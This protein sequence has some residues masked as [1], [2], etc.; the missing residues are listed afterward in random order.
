MTFVAPLP[1]TAAELS[2]RDIL[3]LV[4]RG[5][6]AIML[7]AFLGLAAT[8]LFLMMA[9]PQYRIT[10]LVAPA[11]RAGKAD[12][13]ALLPD[14]PSFALQYL[15]NSVGTQD[16]SDFIRFESALRAPSVAATI[17]RDPVIRDGL[18][19]GGR[20]IFSRAPDLESPAAV[21]ADL[22][23]GI[24]IDPVG[25]TPL[26][27][28]TFTHR[29]PEFGVLLLN[30]LYGATDAMIRAEVSDKARNRAA[31]LKTTLAQVQHPDHRRALTSLLMEQEHILMLLSMDEPFAAVIAEP[32]S[33]SPNP[34]WPRRSLVCAAFIFAGMM[35]GYAVW[36]LRRAP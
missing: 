13:K 21:S 36:G 35:L 24:R 28:V 16:T 11:E 30:R 3:T 20:F 31:Y 10:M 17:L 4:W 29:S 22:E 32:P 15:V 19:Y 9:V 25:N 26:R 14:N 6:V 7:G 12:V 1:A 34:W 33:V 5:R 8:G 23:R 2:F 18:A 27:R